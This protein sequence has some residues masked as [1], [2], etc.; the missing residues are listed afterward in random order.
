MKKGLILIAILLLP[1]IVYL[2]FSMGEHHMARLGY[3]GGIDSISAQGDTFYSPMTFPSLIGED[4]L[5]FSLKEHEG[6]IVMVHLFS[7]ECNDICKTN[8]ATINNYLHKTGFKDK[9]IILS[10][11]TDSVASSLL[12]DMAEKDLY[13][14]DNWFYASVHNSESGKQFLEN[15][16][17]NT[18]EVSDLDQISETKT[19]LFDQS[20][21]LRGFFD[22]K[23]QDDNKKME[24]AINVLIQEPHISWK[25]KK[26]K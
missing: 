7:G 22:L 6:K 13:P 5:E 26:K 25:K 8:I 23:L 16:F 20:L 19:L 3:Y 1:S 10:I 9:W 18:G 2:L 12:Q 14:G 24:D 15:C 21:H 11:S 17:I 4:G